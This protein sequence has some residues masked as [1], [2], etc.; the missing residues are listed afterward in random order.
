DGPASHCCRACMSRPPS[1]LPAGRF[2]GRPLGDWEVG[3][4]ARPRAPRAQYTACSGA[5]L[6]FF[7]PCRGYER[8]GIN[9]RH[10]VPLSLPPVS[11]LAGSASTGCLR[12][13]LGRFEAQR[14]RV[15]LVQQDLDTKKL[16]SLAQSDTANSPDDR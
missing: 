12:D 15:L 3:D 5:S 10:V 8:F 9:L 13:F 1:P 16:R 4:E 6:G 11:Q 7:P 14:P 2:I